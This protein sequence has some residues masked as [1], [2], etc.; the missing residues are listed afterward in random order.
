MAFA[1][2]SDELSAAIGN[3]PQGASS[4]SSSF[5]DA[6][7]EVRA[8]LAPEENAKVIAQGTAHVPGTYLPPAIRDVPTEVRAAYEE[9]RHALSENQPFAQDVTNPNYLAPARAALGL[10]DTA[11]SPITGAGR[12]LLGH[13]LADTVQALGGR[14]DNNVTGPP[15][16]PEQAYKEAKS[17]VDTGMLLAGT[18]GRPIGGIR[19]APPSAE[20]RLTAGQESGDIGLI[21]NEQA[22]YRGQLGETAKNRAVASREEQAAGIQSISDRIAQSFDQLGGQTIA[23]SPQ[24]AA[25]IAQRGLQRSAAIEKAAVDAKYGAARGMGG[26][27]DADTF[28]GMGIE[29]RDSLRNRAEPV[30]VNDKLMPSSAAMLDELDQANELHGGSLLPSSRTESPIPGTVKGV[31]LDGVDQV[32]KR[33]VAM[34]SYAY[35]SG[36][37]SD[38][39]AAGAILNAF[40]DRINAAVNSGAFN[41]NP[42]AVNAWNDARAASAAFKSKFSGDGPAANKMRAIIGRNGQSEI[43]P[44]DVADSIYGSSGVNPNSTNVGVAN[45]VKAALG[46]Q[47][48]EWAAVKQGL[49]SRLT[50]KGPGQTEMGPEMI[51]NRIAKFLDGDG[52]EMAET[53]FNPQDRSLIR[54]FGDLQR[55]LVVP[56]TG[57]NSSDTATFTDRS[58]KAIG[59]KIAFYIGMKLGEHVGGGTVGELLG[60]FAAEKGTELASGFSGGRQIARQMPLVS[61][62]VDKWKAAVK[63]Y[64]RANSAPSRIGLSVATTNL[65]RQLSHIGIDIRKIFPSPASD[66]SQQNNNQTIGQ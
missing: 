8:A 60:G 17:R 65:G 55:K 22:A 37:A 6:H 23:Q 52:K 62:A 25:D 42:A 40:D 63:A 46:E 28:R 59:G 12:S 18:A 45:R 38:G 51:S 34:R 50:E 53:V 39:R 15:E 49:W 54:Q 26:E 1:D 32:R 66:Q 20:F 43:T 61:E 41:G 3:G 10:V 7:S 56:K 11:L 5:D 4:N 47:S 29:V 44:N 16:T 31:S 13:P 58:L 14:F 2:W 30:V 64:D 36:N 21:R 57:F 33:L 19:P 35:G 48:P 9:G 24:E 27:I